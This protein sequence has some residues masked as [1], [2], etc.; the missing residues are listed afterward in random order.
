MK[1]CVYVVLM[2]GLVLIVVE[3]VIDVYY[4]VFCNIVL[5]LFDDWN[6]LL[7]GV[8][9][10][11]LFAF[12]LVRLYDSGLVGIIGNGGLERFLEVV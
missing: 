2:C 7:L 4:W 11:G 10:C 1:G 6:W 5:V 8:I 12:V 9:C 3:G